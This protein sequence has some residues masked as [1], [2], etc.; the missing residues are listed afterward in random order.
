MFLTF[1][2]NFLLFFE[3]LVKQPENHFLAKNSIFKQ[4]D[5][6]YRNKIVIRIFEDFCQKIYF[7]P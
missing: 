2:I 5:W 6:F 4:K 7:L 1:L 3:I